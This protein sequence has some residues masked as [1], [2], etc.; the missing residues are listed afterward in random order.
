MWLNRRVVVVL[1]LGAG[2]LAACSSNGSA[3]NDVG[4][5]GSTVTSGTGSGGASG[6]QNACRV[7]MCQDDHAITDELCDKFLA[8]SCADKARAYYA[9]SLA[10]DACVADGTQDGAMVFHAC[11]MQID[12]YLRCFEVADGGT[13]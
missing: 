7:T 9:C 13:D 6:I 8:S 4:G 5:G 10:N 2:A 11:S 12:A 1:S 3:S